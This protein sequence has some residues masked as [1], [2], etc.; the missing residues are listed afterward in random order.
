VKRQADQQS[1]DHRNVLVTEKKSSRPGSHQ[2][3]AKC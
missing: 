2:V 1:H 3:N